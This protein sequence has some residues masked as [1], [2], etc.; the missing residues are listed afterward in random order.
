MPP[1]IG[2][3]VPAPRIGGV[4]ALS[5]DVDDALLLPHVLGDLRKRG[6][7]ARLGA[8]GALVIASGS[9]NR[10]SVLGFV[11][12]GLIW[13][14]PGRV[15]HFTFSLRGGL[16][17]CLAVAPVAAGL[18]WFCIGSAE[19]AA[20]GLLAPVLWLYGANH[21]LTAIRVPAHLA[22]L[23]RSAPLRPADRVENP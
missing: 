17:L 9:V 20:F 18:G 3:T 5:P 6:C 1:A 15:M 22:G 2:R 23:C 10:G 8:D 11:S 4:I 16:L 19:L 21:V 12:C 7:D 13:L 14:G